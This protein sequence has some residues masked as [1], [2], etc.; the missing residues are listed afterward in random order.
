M[1]NI[2]HNMLIVLHYAILLFDILILLGIVSNTM[3]DEFAPNVY[4]IGLVVNL[5]SVL[6]CFCLGG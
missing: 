1:I 4:A 3:P 5:V 2:M 6:H